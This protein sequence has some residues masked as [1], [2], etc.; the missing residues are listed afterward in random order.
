MIQFPAT[1]DRNNYCN[2]C[3]ECVKAC[4]HENFALRI[5]PFAR[6]I[7]KS[8]RR[9]L[10]EAF[11][12]IALVGLTVV[13]TG[14]MVEPWHDWMD[15][16]AAWIPWHVLGIDNHVAIEKSTFTVVYGVAVLVLTP[17]LLLGAAALAAFLTGRKISIGQA[18]RTYAYMFIPVGIAL[19]LAHNLLHLLKEGSGIVPVIKRTV[20]RYTPLDW[21]VPNWNIAPMASD[22]TIY[23]LQ[24]GVLVLFYAAS[25]Y[26]G[27]RIALQSSP[28]RKTAIVILIP[29]VALSLA[30]T[31]LNIFLLNQP[32]SARH[33]H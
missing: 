23:W 2:L 28:G 14:H 33:L 20:A 31:L 1:L 17:L 5:R 18:F 16:I 7:W 32:M 19:H 27:C 30:F 4:P 8:S 12:A 24:M 3:G 13:V 25:V 22:S 9:H 10:D 15:S 26:L 29:M 6:D 11:L 21:G